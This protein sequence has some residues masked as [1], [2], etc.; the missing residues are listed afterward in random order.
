MHSVSLHP[1]QNKALWFA[2]CRQLK[3]KRNDWLLADTCTQAANHCTL[4]WVGWRETE[5]ITPFYRG[6]HTLSGHKWVP[7]SAYKNLTKIW[8]ETMVF[9][10]QFRQALKMIISLNKY[11]G[12]MFTSSPNCMIPS[13]VAMEILCITNIGYMS[14]IKIAGV[15]ELL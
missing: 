13:S 10:S 11:T 8:S 12:Y 3:I 9:S 2:A 6:R 7:K 4:F 15:E 14:S 5:Y 1:T